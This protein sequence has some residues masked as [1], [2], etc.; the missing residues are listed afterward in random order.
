MVGCATAVSAVRT[1]LD[2]LGGYRILRELGRG[3][4]G[5]VYKAEDLKLKRIVALKVMAPN[6]AADAASRLR[7]VREAV[8]M[9]KVHHD[10]I[11]AIHAIDEDNGV[12]FLAMEFLQGMPLDQWLKAGRK[13]TPAQ[14]LRLGREIAEGAGGRP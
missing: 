14:V 3:G 8:A 1:V 7:F 5:V 11:V 10:N 4:M 12:P 13:A 9:A 2:R 6:L